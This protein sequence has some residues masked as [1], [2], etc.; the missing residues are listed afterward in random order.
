LKKNNGKYKFMERLLNGNHQQSLIDSRGRLM[1]LEPN[2]ERGGRRRGMAAA[3]SGRFHTLLA[4]PFYKME[5]KK[6]I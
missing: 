6:L 5:E 4:M 1:N 2:D 3:A